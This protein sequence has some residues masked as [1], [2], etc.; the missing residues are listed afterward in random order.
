MVLRV[1]MTGVLLIQLPSLLSQTKSAHPPVV[2]LRRAVTRI[3]PI[4]GKWALVFECPNDC[5][6][7]KLWIEENASHTRKLVR[8][9]ERSLSISWA[10]DSRLFLVNDASGS[11]ET[12]CYVY[13]PVTLK[14][15][16]LAKV[17]LAGDHDAAQ[18]LNAG[19]SYLNAQRQTVDTRCNGTR[20]RRFPLQGVYAEG[21]D[22][23]VSSLR[24]NMLAIR[25]HSDA[26]NVVE[27]LRHLAG[28]QI[29]RI[30]CAATPELWSKS[31]AKKQHSRATTGHPVNLGQY[32]DGP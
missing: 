31:F 17:V 10:A 8:E 11:T 20:D 13:D 3:P 26:R 19:H 14:E 22:S 21:F 25:G 16:D 32:L 18:F 24:K 15:T 6:E 29:K 12:R 30:E 1:V 7:R 5:S 23:N 28:L 4:N 2:Q 9:Y 27:E